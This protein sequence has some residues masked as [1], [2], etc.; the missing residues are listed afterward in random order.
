MYQRWLCVKATVLVV[1]IIRCPL[2]AL[3]TFS[4]NKKH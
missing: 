3:I 4:S 1:L 2:A